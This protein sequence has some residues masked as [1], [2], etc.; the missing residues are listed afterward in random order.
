[1]NTKSETRLLYFDILRIIAAFSVVMLHSAAQFW[2]DLPV[3]DTNW[4]ITNS[5]NALFRFGVPI[6]VMISG[7]LF[8]NPE[9]ETNIR[10]LFTHNIARILILFIFWSCIYGFYDCLRF[11]FKTLSSKDFIREFIL[12]RYHLWFLPMIACLYCLVPVLHCFVKHAER[13]VIKYFLLLF[14]VFQIGI[15]TLKA[16]TTQGEILYIFELMNIPL[17]CSYAGYFILGYYISYIGI[18]KKYHRLIYISAFL[19]AVCNVIFGNLLAQ[20]HQEPVADVYDSYGFFTFIIVV[21]IYLYFTEHKEKFALSSKSSR[22]IQE[23][24]ACTLGV[25]VMH[26]GLMEIF[27]NNGFH[28]L[29]FP[30]IIGVPIFAIICFILCTFIAAIVRRIPFVGKFIC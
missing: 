4:I 12:G 11:D 26:V 27:K 24:S 28:P 25:Y 20:K 9:K 29:S 14:I 10:K 2:Y 17:V 5:Y 21:A 18:D 15:F 3:S 23:L 1:M 30:I 7:S 8:L 19:S 13:S 6:F 22:L 16:F